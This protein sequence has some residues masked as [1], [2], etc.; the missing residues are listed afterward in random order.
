MRVR[1]ADVLASVAS[2][3]FAPCACTGAT[4]MCVPELQP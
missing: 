2:T 1:G 3:A 4:S